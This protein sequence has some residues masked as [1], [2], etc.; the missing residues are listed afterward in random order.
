M[1]TFLINI[2]INDEIRIGFDCI[3]KGL[4]ELSKFGPTT[5]HL[6]IPLLLFSNGFERILK[7]LYCCYFNQN[8]SRYPKNI[9][10]RKINHSLKKLIEEL[11]NTLESYELY[12]RASARID[13]L[14]FL[15]YNEDFNEFIAIINEFSKNGRYYNLNVV[16]DNGKDYNKP[17]NLISKFSNRIICRY[18]NEK[19][20]ICNPPYNTQLFFDIFNK[21]LIEIVQR[22]TRILCFAFT[23]G[24]Y[25]ADARQLS[26]GLLDD[27][28]L[29]RED[30]L[31]SINFVH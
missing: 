28:L 22:F 19:E 31:S 6:F 16:S 5:I 21:F 20:N 17:E 25:G 27:F 9:E 15:K 3:K 11:I 13:D 23:Q 30:Q 1:K 18:P 12:T 26:A 8:N 2:S 14:N 4:I 10:L 24:A 29:L 7:V